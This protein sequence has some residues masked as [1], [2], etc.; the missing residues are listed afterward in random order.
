MS[1]FMQC[2][3][4]RLEN[5]IKYEMTKKLKCLI[6]IYTI[7]FKSRKGYLS[8]HRLKIQFKRRLQLDVEGQE[9]FEVSETVNRSF[10]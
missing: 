4:I 7:W 8:C 3:E 6:Q 5:K 10:N 9:E 1:H 2:L